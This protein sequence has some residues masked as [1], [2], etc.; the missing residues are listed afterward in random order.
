MTTMPFQ[1]PAPNPFVPPTTAPAQTSGPTFGGAQP[2]DA[3][4]VGIGRSST[5]GARR[6]VGRD[7][8]DWRSSAGQAGFDTQPAD[9][10]LQSLFDIPKPEL[11]AIQ[12]KMYDAGFYGNVSKEAVVFGVVDDVTWKAFGDL[13]DMSAQYVQSGREVTWYELLDEVQAAR[14]EQG[15]NLLAEKKQERAPFV[16]RTTNPDD[17]ERVA[18]HVATSLLGEKADPNLVRQIISQFQAAEVSSQRQAYGAAETGG[19]V[20]DAPSV[21]TFAAGAIEEADPTA[22]TAYAAAD[23][24]MQNFLSVLQGPFEG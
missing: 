5:T 12:T 4:L 3:P 6:D 8:R 11:R 2:S 23:G 21:E 24:V 7:P 9:R 13:L 1:A 18:Q 19:T 22:V 15:S 10:V 17:V 20:A 16:A 14:K